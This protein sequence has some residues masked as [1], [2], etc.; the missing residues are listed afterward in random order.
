MKVELISELKGHSAPIYKI[1]LLDGKLFSVS[2]DKML[3]SWD[4]K[5][6]EPAPF[7]IKAESAIY[8]FLINQQHIF[9]GASSGNVNVIDLE[10]KVEIRN[11]KIHKKGVYTLLHIR[12][13]QLL[14]TGG[15]DGVINFFDY[16]SMELIRSIKI[17]DKKIRSGG[18]DSTTEKLYISC[19]EGMVRVFEL[20]YFN[21]IGS[22][23]A[24]TESI[25]KLIIHPSKSVLITGG[26]DG[27]LKFWNLTDHS[28]V[29]A[30][31][32]H[33][34]TIYD[35]QFN[36]SGEKCV[37]VSRDKSVKLWSGDTFEVISKLERKTHGGHTHSVNSSVWLNDTEF[38]TAGDDRTIKRWKIAEE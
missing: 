18:Y 26:K 37:T 24:S 13:H 22:F 2:S 20:E 36:G 32:A 31:P 7:S 9:L 35:I 4:L 25:N 6:N 15:G 21:E 19:G 29:M 34:M 14:M 10:A 23:R 27:Y 38:F 17:S 28:E 30:I 3:A 12:D 5:I 8:T 1:Q 11:F 33:N 16:Q